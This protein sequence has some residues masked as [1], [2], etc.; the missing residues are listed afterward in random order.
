[1]CGFGVSNIT[2]LQSV[3]AKCQTRG[4][5]LTSSKVIN[6]IE[7][8]HNLLHITGSFI[9]QPFVKDDIVCLFNGEIYNYRSFGTYNSDGECIADVYKHYGDKFIEKLD[10]E[11]AIFLVDFS[12]QKIIIGVDP[13]ACKPLWYEFKG[14][15]FCVGSYNSQLHGLGFN[16]GKKLR[17]NTTQIY[18]LKS[19]RLVDEFS[20]VRFDI[21]QHKTTF[22]SWLSAFSDSIKKRILNTDK[23]MFVGMSSGYDS[24]AIAC[25]LEKQQ[26]NFKAYSITNNENTDVLNA[27]LK[28]ISSA[29]PFIMTPEEF[30]RWKQEL[31]RNCEDFHYQDQFFDYDIKKD[32]ASMGLSAICHRANKEGRRIYFSGQGADEIISDYGFGGKKIYKHSSFGGMFPKDLTGFFP[33][34]SF[35]DGTQ[36]QYL[37][38]EEYVAGH[39]GIETRY[40]FLDRTVVQEFLWLSA[41]LKNSKY[42]SCLDEY[43]KVNN[44]PYQPSEKRGFHVVEKGKKS[45]TL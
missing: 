3:N 43:L 38:K 33:W 1:M 5:D 34:H 24:G 16:N 23:G 29:E 20:N 41:D 37:N 21:R 35:W 45:K 8:L 25:E 44:F 42:K 28:L 17:A 26:A 27:R 6:G 9:T 10:G 18:D 36:I 22:D 12:K 31:R 11:F 7:F 4:P 40:P 30:E 32:Q 2:K 13:F 14:D 19:L 15:K 39:F